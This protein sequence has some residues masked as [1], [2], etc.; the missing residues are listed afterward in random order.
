MFWIK[1]QLEINSMNIKFDYHK[2]ILSKFFNVI[3][4]VQNFIK[5]II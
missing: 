1:F 4:R 5:D 3:I 2:S